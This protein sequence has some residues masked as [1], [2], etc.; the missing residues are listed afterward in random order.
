MRIVSLISSA[1]EIVY[2]LG[3]GES[4]V[5]RSHECDY[6]ERVKALPVC[7]APKFDIHG[8]SAE[9]DQRVK[10][11]LRDSGS[12]YQVYSDVLNQLKP[13]LIVTQSQCDVCAVSLRD[14]EAAVCE[15]VSS[16]PKVV[17]LQPNSLNDIW[18][19]IRR[20][21]DAA[22]VPKRGEHLVASMKMRMKAIADRANSWGRRPSVACIEW[23][24][25]LMAAGN[26]MP[27]L[28]NMAG[29]VN[30]FGVA[31]KHSPAMTWD[32]LR[33]QDPEVIFVLPCGFDLPRTRQEMPALA[34]RPEWGQLRAVRNGRVFVCDGNAYFNRPGPRLV[35]A[36]EMLAE[37][38]F[39]GAFTFGHK[40]IQSYP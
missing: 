6:P 32:E 40:G 39:P 1:T 34:N 22:G 10:D 35:E 11:T 36:L 7:T 38:I 37:A 28:V 31:G 21:A 13:D 4:L 25:P 12:V 29:G 14:V 5:G 16:K 30:L 9:I 23:I 19:D 18:D 24:D 26:W 8:S 27:E 3:L 17:A 33:Q 15:I 2:A 20:V